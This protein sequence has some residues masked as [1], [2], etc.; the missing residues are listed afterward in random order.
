[1]E[2]TRKHTDVTAP[3]SYAESSLIL[4][5]SDREALERRAREMRGVE[6]ARHARKLSTWSA[7]ALRALAK[8]V[9]ALPGILAQRRA[10][11]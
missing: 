2:P 6:I 8:R 5:W 3:R 1:M 4:T 11:R 9:R 10:L 7:A